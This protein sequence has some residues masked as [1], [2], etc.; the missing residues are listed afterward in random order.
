M[1]A[2]RKIQ[3]WEPKKSSKFSSWVT[4]MPENEILSI[5]Q[6]GG[7]GWTRAACYGLLHSIRKKLIACSARRSDSVGTIKA[8]KRVVTFL[9]VGVAGK[10]ESKT[11]RQGRLF[12]SWG[13]A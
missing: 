8:G 4:R 10:N 11:K 12:R 5:P 2:R 6:R 9:C 7:G 1:G 3:S 13:G